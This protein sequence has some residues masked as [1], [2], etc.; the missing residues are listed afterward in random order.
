MAQIPS[1]VPFKIGT[2]PYTCVLATQTVEQSDLFTN[3]LLGTY[4]R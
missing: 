1:L 4:Q 2:A 3:G